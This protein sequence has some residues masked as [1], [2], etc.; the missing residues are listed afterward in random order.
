M[1]QANTN[2]SLKNLKTQVGQLALAMQNQSKDAFPIDT[3]NNPKDY[4]A[5][6]L[7]SGREFENRKENE[8]RKSEK[9]KK[10]EIEEEIKLG[11]SEKTKESKKKKSAARTA[12]RGKKLEEERRG[13][14]IYAL[15]SISSEAAKSKDGRAVL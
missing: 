8:K 3:K 11:S 10:V 13:A 15:C 4:M 7:R 5:V 12:S 9:E 14:S 1:F 6:T 2:T